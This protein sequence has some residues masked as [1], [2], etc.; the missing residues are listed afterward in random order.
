MFRL[1]II[2]LL[3]AFATLAF[4]GCA[5][6]E[7]KK[8]SHFQKGNAYFENG[9]FKS[10][11]LEFKNVIQIDA[12]YMAAYLMLGETNLKLGDAK[13]AFRA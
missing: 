3:F 11:R 8:I 7:E 2:F 6:D 12:K 1:K 5:S 13:K 9:E 10:A 4:W